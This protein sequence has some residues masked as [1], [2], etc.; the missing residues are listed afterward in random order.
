[1]PTHNHSASSITAGAH[2]HTIYGRWDA[3]DGSYLPRTGTTTTAQHNS[4]SSSSGNHSHTI[5][6]ANNGS[7]KAHN[8]IQP[9]ISVYIWKRVS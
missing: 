4:Q 7:G 3:H 2:T 8:N 5:N 1:M 9:Y 6:I